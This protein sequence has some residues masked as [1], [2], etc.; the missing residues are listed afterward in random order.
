MDNDREKTKILAYYLPQFHSIPENDEWW[1]KGYTEWTSIKRENTV[2]ENLQ[3]LD[4]NYYNL[5][6]TSTVLWQTNL[7]QTYGIYGFVYYHYYF[8]GKKLLEKPAENLLANK[9][10]NQ[11]FCFCWANH[12][13][14]RSW[15][16]NSKILVKQEYGNKD[17][18]H[19]HFD[20]LLPFFLDE[21]YIKVCGKP[22][23]IIFYN[24]NEKEALY[25][26]FNEYARENGLKGIFFAQIVNKIKPPFLKESSFSADSIILREPD[27]CFRRMLFFER[28]KR[29][30][31]KYY[32]KFAK[33]PVLS[34]QYNGNT[35]I[36]KTIRNIKYFCKQMQKTG[37][38][39]WIGAF[40]GW[41]NTSRHGLRGQKI[42]CFSKEK[43]LRY[44]VKL[45]EIAEKKHI[46]YIFFNAWNEWAEG[47]ILE[48]D[49]RNK[50]FFLK[51]IKSVFSSSDK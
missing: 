48:P 3:P 17:D 31:I 32:I 24:F 47:M 12:D 13:W 42:S 45:K 37:K 40:T 19:R 28:C 8:C 21:R 41:D 33:K 51:S 35:Q 44:L 46:E 5:L 26:S 29:R 49:K 7:A 39:F 9:T 16:G 6:D 20:Y 34:M 22:L 15:E 10:I 18:W 38:M 14:I 43:Y 4:D 27:V 1:G 25:N 23:F 50:Y 36:R 2:S 11:K 30:L